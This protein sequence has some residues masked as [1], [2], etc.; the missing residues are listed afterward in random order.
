MYDTESPTEAQVS[1][2]KN[3]LDQR[4]SASDR[5]HTFESL[6]FDFRGRPKNEEG[7]VD[8]VLG[9]QELGEGRTPNFQVNLE[10]GQ[11]KDWGGSQEGGD[12]YSAVMKVLGCE[13]PEAVQYVAEKINYQPSGRS[14]SKRQPTSGKSRTREV[15]SNGS[16]LGPVDVETAQKWNDR[17]FDE[18]NEFGQKVLNYWAGERGLS[19]E[20]INRRGF[21]L[22][23][24]KGKWWTFIPHHIDAG[25]I[26]SGKLFMASTSSGGIVRTD[27]GSKIVAS[28]GSPAIWMLNQVPGNVGHPVV[29]AEGEVDTMH[30]RQIG[31]PA[32]TETHGAGKVKNDDIKRVAEH[33]AVQAN[34]VIMAYD[35]DQAGQN[36]QQKIAEALTRLGAIVYLLQWPD[37]R[38][39]GHDINDEIREYGA[40]SL[41]ELVSQAGRYEADIQPYLEFELHK[42]VRRHIRKVIIPAPHIKVEEVDQEP[43]LDNWIYPGSLTLLQGKQKAGGKTTFMLHA[44]SSI[45]VGKSFIGSA[46]T[47]SNV[48][49]MTEQNAR[50]LKPAMDE[51]GLS[52]QANFYVLQHNDTSHLTWKETIYAA[53]YRAEELDIDLLVIDTFA[54]YAQLA[55]DAENN[56]G[57]VLETIKPL[58]KIA[59]QGIAVVLVHHERK[60]GG[61][62]WDAGRGSGAI[63]GACDTVISIRRS[64]GARD[65]V[66]ELKAISRYPDVPSELVIELT[67]DGYVNQGT[68]ANVAAKEARETITSILPVS[69]DNA[70]ETSEVYDLAKEQGTT[71]S[72]CKKLLPR[73]I[74]KGV[75]TRLGNGV[76]GDPYRYYRSIARY[77][78][79][80]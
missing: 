54:Q 34:G 12:L 3:D 18:S 44:C 53:A 36:A 78:E 33:P 16:S 43:L 72:M 31:L 60:A 6:G 32:I 27:D 37:D 71:K 21:G 79:Q 76:K 68:Q 25:E 57:A 17:L 22:R 38:P 35:N 52:D 55:N 65:T 46:S 63:Q 56:A 39:K 73:L 51:A 26:Q 48:L 1:I 61:E 74:E 47:R 14:S 8:K 30:A 62:V 10:T 42:D 58:Q 15:S 50:T 11:W 75:I 23:K 41:R 28:Y 77:D 80:T 70:L 4:L 59:G 5:R 7:E 64:Q 2:D 40:D 24:Y 67:D 29:W 69:P 66:R 45:T 20:N 19:R 49:Y 13:F 9:P